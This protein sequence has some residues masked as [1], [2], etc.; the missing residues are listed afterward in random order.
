M[1][2][3][4][5]ALA[6]FTAST[7]P[8]TTLQAAP[9]SAPQLQAPVG[10]AQLTDFSTA[11]AWANPPGTTQYFLE[12]L[13]APGVAGGPPDG[14][15][16]TL[17]RNA[18]T[19]FD[20]LGPQIG[21]DNYVLLPD[22]TYTWRVRAS[23]SA[24]YAPPGD[25]SYGPP[26]QRT[27][28]TPAVTSSGISAAEPQDGGTV[29]KLTPRL[30]WDNPDPRV[31]YYEVQVSKDP[32]FNMGVVKQAAPLY[33]E[34]I[35]G[36]QTDPLNSYQ[37]RDQ[38]A[39]EPAAKYYWRVRPR[40]QGDGKPLAW[41]RNFTFLTSSGT[42]HLER[43]FG[44]LTFQKITNMVQPDGGSGRYFAT[45]QRGGVRSFK[46][47]GGA[48][49]VFLD[50]RDRVRNSDTEEGLLGIAFDP[51]YGSNGQFYLYYSAS[52]PLR[53]QLSRFYVRPDDPNRADPASE[54]VI[55]QFPKPFGNHNGGQILFGPDGYL[56]IGVGDGGSGGDPMGNGQ[57]T[58][59]LL[60]KIHRIDV[61]TNGAY[62]IPPDNPFA[63]GARPEIWAYGMRNPWR[64]SFD[65]SGRLWVADVGQNLWEEVDIVHGGGNYGW[66]IMEGTLCFSPSRNCNMNG[67][68]MPL[69]DYGH[70]QGCSVTGGYVYRGRSAP[71]LTGAYVYGD[72]CSGKI[73]AL[74]E[75]GGAVARQILIADS[76]LSISSFAEDLAGELYVLN[77]SEGP[78][79]IT[80]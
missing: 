54:Q 18:E 27:F 28:R 57:N 52:N 10:R 12:V 50:I 9:T 8:D 38:F 56:Y 24:V 43:A 34:L 31:F 72:Y 69:T 63:G 60:G 6:L 71:S 46:A 21:Q 29:D 11:L 2:Y 14:P 42:P 20:L 79:R 36:G 75:Q 70:D 3:S 19:S 32:S 64:F 80:E 49:S 13:P 44:N 23:D 33:W 41:S 59:R 55:I 45:E 47:D 17:V 67:L 40:V 73:W 66:N 78:Y 62:Q 77:W 76:G 53:N 26:A 37:V 51:D 4:L 48:S 25:P 61:R 58:S 1:R 16:I 74:W 22:M 65:P 30:R 39:L 15:A 35:H 7:L 68:D 5:A